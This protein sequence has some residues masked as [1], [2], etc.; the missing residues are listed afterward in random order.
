M[1]L[2]YI[3]KRTNKSEDLPVLS[4]SSVVSHRHSKPP[5]HSLN[6][7]AITHC[8][9]RVLYKRFKFSPGYFWWFKYVAL[10]F[11][12]LYT[13]ILFIIIIVIFSGTFSAAAEIA[14]L[15]YADPVTTYLFKYKK[16]IKEIFIFYLRY[17]LEVHVIQHRFINIITTILSLTRKYSLTLFGLY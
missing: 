11:T 16:K 2:L 9:S 6:T 3:F 7:L 15:A 13:L 4:I 10:L 8:H 17:S 1:D 14:L 5:I 12:F